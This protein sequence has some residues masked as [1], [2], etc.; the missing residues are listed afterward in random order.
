[1]KKYFIFCY[2]ALL[3]GCMHTETNDFILVNKENGHKLGPF[4]YRDGAEVSVNEKLYEISIVHSPEKDAVTKKLKNCKIDKIEIADTP[5][6]VII[7]HLAETSNVNMIID[8]TVI[9]NLNVETSSDTEDTEKNNFSSPK[10]TISLSNISAYDAL[11]IICQKTGLN[12]KIE[13]A[14]IRIVILQPQL[15]MEG[16]DWEYNGDFHKLISLADKIVI[17]NGG[18][19]CCEHVDKQEILLEIKD[20]NE[21]ID[22]NKNIEFVQK[23]FLACCFCCGYPGID[24]YFGDYRLALTAVHH[25]SSLCW[26]GFYDRN[27]F[28]GSPTLTQKSSRWLARWL[29]DHK[30]PDRNNEFKEIIQRG[31]TIPE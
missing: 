29:L 12:W 1:M 18:F 11:N 26:N 13:N 6:S 14:A 2:F 17:R 22:F 4:Q 7:S 28:I 15:D 24:W 9:E 19:D 16:K 8:N 30:I 3:A 21:I 31:N 20:R 5:I 27:I 23:Q 25:G 10:I